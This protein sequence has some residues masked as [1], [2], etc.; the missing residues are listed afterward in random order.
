LVVNIC[1]TG[2][3]YRLGR[4]REQ[5]SGLRRTMVSERFDPVEIISIRHWAKS[6]MRVR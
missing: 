2:E 3:H 4:R 6:S 1:L 5:S